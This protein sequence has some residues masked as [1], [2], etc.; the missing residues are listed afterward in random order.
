MINT[1]KYKVKFLRDFSRQRKLKR[2]QEKYNIWINNGAV[3][4]I[5]HYGKKIILEEYVNKYKP[6]IFIETGTYNGHMV[7][8]MLD[9]FEKVYSIELDEILYRKAKEKFSGYKHVKIL[10]GESDKVLKQILPEVQSSCLFWLDAHFSGGNTA[11][12]D[13][14]TPIMRELECIFNHPL[15]DN[16][17][18]LIDDARCFNGTNDYPHITALSNYICEKHPDWI[19][20]VKDDVIRTF[21]KNQESI[22]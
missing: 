2:F 3:P 22:L 16:H 20:E 14:E 10:Q 7:L 18:L 15:V 5:P 19:F 4:P 1:I 8:S 12:A 11:K 9:K 21:N 17:I 13:I 6:E